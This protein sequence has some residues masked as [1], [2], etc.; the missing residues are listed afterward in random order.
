MCIVFAQLIVNDKNHGVTPFV[1]PFRE[2]E[3]HE[4]YP[5]IIVGDCGLK[6]GL[7]GVDNGFI[8]FNKVKV[9]Y[10]SMLDRFVSID[11]Q[12]E[13]HSPIPNQGKRFGLSMAALSNGRVQICSCQNV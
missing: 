9:P 7:N 4:P 8:N 3:T 5:G 6:I 2:K 12:G 11:E 1:I 13:F 10:D